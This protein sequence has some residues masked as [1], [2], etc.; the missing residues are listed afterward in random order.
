[1]ESILLLTLVYFLL[2]F[3]AIRRKNKEIKYYKEVIRIQNESIIEDA[4]KGGADNGKES[5]Q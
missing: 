5:Q 4:L 1:M 3:A 2:L